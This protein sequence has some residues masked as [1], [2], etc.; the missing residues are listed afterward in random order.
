MMPAAPDSAAPAH[1]PVLLGPLLA[2]L[3][4][5]RGVWLDGTFGAGGYARGLLEAGAERVIGID[6]DPSALEMARDWAAAFGDRLRLV[7]GNFAE[8]D[9]WPARRWTAWCW[10]SVSPRCSSTSPGGAFPFPGTARS[11]CA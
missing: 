3:A 6:R 5:V 8:L 4:P 2:S 10:I 7:Q 1:V 9:R 11:T